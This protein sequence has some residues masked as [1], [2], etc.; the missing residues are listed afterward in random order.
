MRYHLDQILVNTVILLMLYL[1]NYNP[2]KTTVADII[3]AKPKNFFTVLE[4][5]PVA[6]SNGLNKP[7]NEISQSHNIPRVIVQPPY[8]NFS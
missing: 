2:I 5:V 3:D 6:G 8:L 1:R 7:M 4:Q